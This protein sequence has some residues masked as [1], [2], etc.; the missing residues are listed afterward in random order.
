MIIRN[1]NIACYDIDP[2]KYA[3]DVPIDN[4]L[5]LVQAVAWCMTGGK[6]L[7]EPLVTQS[8]DECMRHHVS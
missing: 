7:I 5:S 8:N 4:N 1:T 2:Q 6:P 3:L